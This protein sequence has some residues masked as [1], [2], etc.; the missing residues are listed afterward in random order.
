[1]SDDEGGLF[2]K[3]IVLFIRA[4]VWLFKKGA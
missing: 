2:G 4:F 3:L 1:M